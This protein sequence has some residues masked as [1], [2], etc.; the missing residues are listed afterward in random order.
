M[1]K[2]V[3]IANHFL[4]GG[5]N[6]SWGRLNRFLSKSFIQ[7]AFLRGTKDF[8][9]IIRKIGTI[10]LAFH[11]FRVKSK[12]SSEQINTINIVSL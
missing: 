3:E 1:K 10:T 7:E 2:R 11:G 5:L 6:F 4:R 9:D 12:I 8:V